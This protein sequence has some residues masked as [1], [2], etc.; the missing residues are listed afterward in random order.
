MEYKIN[1][2]NKHS[3]IISDHPHPHQN[4]EILKEQEDSFS[5][6]FIEFKRGDLVRIIRLENSYLNV[7]K[8]Y[9]GE[10][11]VYRKGNKTA[12]LFLETRNNANFIVF[13]IEHFVRR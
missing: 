5:N 11:K 12:S 10:I 7:Y 4:K 13:P 6:N 1:R 2:K 8:G 3:I 9:N